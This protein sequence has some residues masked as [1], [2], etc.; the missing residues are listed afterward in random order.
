[1]V[2][3]KEYRVERAAAADE[4]V[5]K[6]YG[7]FLS[8]LKAGEVV[9]VPMLYGRFE[10]SMS[11]AASRESKLTR[12]RQAMLYAVKSGMATD[13]SV[14][15]EMPY[16]DFQRIPVVAKWLGMLNPSNVHRVRNRHSGTRESYGYGMYR[17][18][19][20]LAGKTWSIATRTTNDD[21]SYRDVRRDVQVRDVV[22]LLEL[23]LE[24]GEL[25]RD[26]T[27]IIRQ[28]FADMS[29]QKKFS[30][31][32]MAQ[33]QS[34]LKSFFMSHEIQYGLQLPR[35]VMQ[36]TRAVDEEW[37]NND[38]KMS[39]LA[40]M[41]T[42][43]RPSI[44]DKAV[45]LSKF[46]RGMDQ[47][48]MADRFNYTAFDQI[49]A[50]MGTDDHLSWDLDKCPVPIVLTRVKTNFKHVGFL[51]R[52]AI[53]ANID[54]ITERAQ[55]TGGPLHRGDGHPLYLSQHGSPITPLWIG[56]RF[57]SL[58]IRSGLCKAR[59]DGAM[60]STR[61][62]HQMR[63]LLKSTLIDAGCRIDVADHVI[64]H[65]PKDAYEKQSILYP[66]SLRREYAKASAKINIFT[67][68]ETTLD[69]PDDIHQLR[70]KYEADHKKLQETLAA[71]AAVNGRAGTEGGGAAHGPVAEMIASL[72][73]DMRKLQME[74]DEAAAAAAG[75]G[76]GAGGG[77]P[78]YVCAECSLIHTERT[79]PSCGSSKR[80]VYAEAAAGGG[81]GR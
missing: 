44:R 37:E 12:L 20:W 15:H 59:K 34:A 43:G 31:S 49:S 28:F 45:I 55:L 68:I 1:M 66:D 69:G 78:E 73:N 58:A 24:K 67:N 75:A 17:L 6:G 22:H 21:G 42:V 81:K 30:R 63:H 5:P 9:T 61:H 52:D 80:R 46:H 47:T 27:A 36:G 71:A 3:P 26:L 79:C 53:K 4:K 57:R 72:Q 16:R 11:Q 2:A 62:T 19:N 51:E 65:A 25:D 10:G 13:V 38:L 33:T 50:H 14:R 74:R 35:Y 40:R 8:R 29:A 64:G 18:N 48:T 54:W 56:G 70:A 77:S 7:Q 39:D 76:A 23:A 32:V 60:A 41:L